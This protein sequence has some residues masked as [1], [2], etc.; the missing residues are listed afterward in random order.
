MDT[1]LERRRVEPAQQ[2]LASEGRI[3]SRIDHIVTLVK[4]VW[5]EGLAEVPVKYRVTLA[6]SVDYHHPLVCSGQGLLHQPF[7]ELR[8]RKLQV[9]HLRVSGS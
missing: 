7:E 9:N 1:V 5:H 8:P 6:N 3:L 2:I 4:E